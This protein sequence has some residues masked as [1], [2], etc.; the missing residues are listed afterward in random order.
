MSDSASA[1][2]F[3]DFGSI[4]GCFGNFGV[5]VDFC[6]VAVVDFAVVDFAVVVEVVDVN[7]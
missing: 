4:F 3:V 1:S 5:V 7:S 2:I 6:S